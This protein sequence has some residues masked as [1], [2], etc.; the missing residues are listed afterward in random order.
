LGSEAVGVEIPES[1][2][3]SFVAFGLGQNPKRFG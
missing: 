3:V 1:V 2:L